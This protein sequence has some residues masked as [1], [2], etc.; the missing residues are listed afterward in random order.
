[1][2][3]PIVLFAMSEEEISQ[4]KYFIERNL[5]VQIEILENGEVE[6]S[7]GEVPEAD[8]YKIYYADNPD[9]E[10]FDFLVELDSVTLSY[11]STSNSDYEFYHLTYLIEVNGGTIE[12]I[13]GN[14]YQTLVIGNQEWMVENLKVTHYRNGDPIPNVTDNI[15]WKELSTG[16]YC[17]YNNSATNGEIYGALY[18][19]YTVND[20]RGLAPDGWRVPT[21]GEIMELEMYLGMNESEA[22]SSGGRGTNEGSKLAGAHDLWQNGNLRNNPEFDTSGFSFF[23]GGSRQTGYNYD[24][25]FHWVGERGYLWSSTEYGSS[26]A[27]FRNLNRSYTT[28]YRNYFTK[29]NGFS[30]RC[31]R[32]VE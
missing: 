20:P 28:V 27:R 4:N 32:D 25:T 2:T 30:V 18:N 7:W 31:V 17:F 11:Q 23:P 21:D 14:V 19:W 16:A 8:A 12:D 13:D 6:L 3:I 22:N 9:A 10:T 29:Q 5:D 15:T 24:G 26:N 1:M